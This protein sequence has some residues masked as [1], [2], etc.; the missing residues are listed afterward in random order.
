MIDG[1]PI[2]DDLRRGGG[3]SIATSLSR[4]S[5]GGGPSVLSGL[6]PGPVCRS[7]GCDW[8]FD[9]KRGRLGALGT[10]KAGGMPSAADSTG[11][12]VIGADERLGALPEGKFCSR[13]NS[14]CFSASLS[15]INNGDGQ[16]VSTGE[17]V[18]KGGGGEGGSGACF[19]ML[20]EARGGGATTLSAG[21]ESV[22][23][24]GVSKL[25]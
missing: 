9:C 2:I 11:I 17:G 4:V 6:F 14:D 16:A 10:P 21:A 18:E 15:N 19:S 12:E 23:S 5:K 13:S 1:R 3:S 20:D 7:R 25:T 8:D 24:L 22:F